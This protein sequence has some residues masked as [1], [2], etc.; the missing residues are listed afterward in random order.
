M[1]VGVNCIRKA[2]LAGALAGVAAF[3]VGQSYLG[4]TDADYVGGGG[5][6]F[7]SDILLKWNSGANSIT[8]GAYGFL[9]WKD[10]NTGGSVELDG[11]G[12]GTGQNFYSL[13]G[14]FV[15][16]ND[17]SKFD[18][19]DISSSTAGL[20]GY[21][22][23]TLNRGASVLSRSY[24]GYDTAFEHAFA[25]GATSTAKQLLGAG[26]QLAVWAAVYGDGSAWGAGNYNAGTNTLTLGGFSAHDS[27]GSFGTI[28]GYARD[29][30]EAARLGSWAMGTNA[31]TLWLDS[32]AQGNKLGQDQFT[33]DPNHPPQS[34]PEPFTMALMGGSAMAGYIRM[35]K[36]RAA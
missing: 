8:A 14:Q 22:M 29:Y 6:L 12:F 33:I 21:A 15:Y 13:C 28:V 18:I 10:L 1:Y 24:G 36:R 34:V 30:Y 20:P 17:P 3:S 4:S 2:V 23:S 11:M 35:R 25:S 7:A 27:D 9:Y 5:H 19:W 16:L 26:I 32:L 31:T